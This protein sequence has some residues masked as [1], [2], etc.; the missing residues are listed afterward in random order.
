MY[1]MILM[2]S[3]QPVICLT[4]PS[5]EFTGI[6]SLAANLPAADITSPGKAV[7]FNTGGQLQNDSKNIL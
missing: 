5:T 7:P 6:F 1:K 3:R 2:N 4:N